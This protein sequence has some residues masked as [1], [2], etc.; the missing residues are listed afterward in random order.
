VIINPKYPAI[1]TGCKLIACSEVNPAPNINLL[2]TVNKNEKLGFKD[3]KFK[4]P[5]I[6][7][8]ENFNKFGSVIMFKSNISHRVTPVVFGERKTIVFFLKEPKK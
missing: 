2:N 6:Y 3:S 4:N 1:A 5:E 7:S 8:V